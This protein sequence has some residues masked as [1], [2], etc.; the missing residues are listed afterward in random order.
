MFIISDVVM[1]NRVDLVSIVIECRGRDYRCC[2]AM[3]R[4][5]FIRRYKGTDVWRQPVLRYALEAVG[6]Q[7]LLKIVL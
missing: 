6:D 4:D 7:R 3:P 2:D 1:D 5:A